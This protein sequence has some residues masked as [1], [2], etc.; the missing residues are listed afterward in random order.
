[1]R[2]PLTLLA[3]LLSCAA[4]AQTSGFERL[5]SGTEARL[6][7]RDAASGRYAPR[8]LLVPTD[9]PYASRVGQVLLAFV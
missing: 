5:P 8:P 2:L 4:L 9:A 6:F 3:V 7:R 1:M